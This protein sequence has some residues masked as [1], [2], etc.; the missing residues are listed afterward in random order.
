MANI[1]D[2]IINVTSFIFIISIIAFVHEYG[3]YKIAKISGVKI[4]IFS[5]GFGPEIFGWTNK[6]QT[7]WKICLFPFGGYVKMFGDS[8]AA[9]VPDSSKI[10]S[11]T[12]DDFKYAFH[13]KPLAV[14]SAIVAAG[15]LANFIFAIIILTPLFYIYGKPSSLAQINIV[16]ENS[17]ADKG[18]LKVG[19]LIT[20]I[21][22]ITINDFE[23]LRKIVSI[24]PKINLDF[25]IN[26]NGNI[27]HLNIIPDLKEHEDMFGNKIKVGSIGIASNSL[28]YKKMG[29]ASALNESIK[30][31]YSMC[32]LTIKS[33]G[34]MI[35]GKRGT[36][37][38]GGPIRIAKYTG[39]S[40]KKGLNV[41]LWFLA[42]LSINLGLVNLF[43]IPMLD[44]GHLFY[45]MIEALRG[46]PLPQNI[47]ILGF[48]LGFAIICFLMLFS[49]FNDIKNLFIN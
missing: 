34:Q 36:E 13:T 41:T 5:I 35:T 19:D 23:D 4:E 33:L 20:H 1:I 46:K 30:E 43:P 17:A 15:P 48:K 6:E 14:K 38:L 7:R 26:R 45:Y 42:I 22:N 25:A 21:D 9:S 3:H 12:E 32:T 11:L 49:T 27:L 37:E 16:N 28:A 39:Q 47:Q 2:I 18:G 8:N 29:L 24:N 10:V 40:I 31:T 44:G